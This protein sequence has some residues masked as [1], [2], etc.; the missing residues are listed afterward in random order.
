MKFR[1]WRFPISMLILVVF[2]SVFLLRDGEW[3]PL[4]KVVLAT[5]FTTAVT[6][7]GV[8]LI[9]AAVILALTVALGR[10]YCALL[11]P[12]GMVQDLFSR[13]G[14]RLG[15]SRLHYVRF[16]F[17]VNAAFMVAAIVFAGILLLDPIAMFGSLALPAG[18]LV[19]DGLW[20]ARRFY[21]GEISAFAAVL[22]VFGVLVVVPLFFGRVFCDAACPVGTLFRLLGRLPGRR[23]VI[24]PDKCVSCGKCS[25]VCAARCAD[26]MGKRIDAERCLLC[27]DCA[28]ACRFDAVAYGKE[29]VSGRRGFL[30]TAG[31]V[32]L[33]GTFVFSREMRQRLGIGYADGTRVTPPGTGGQVGHAGRCVGCQ[34]CVLSCPV[35]II[36]ADGLDARPV[37]DFRQGYCQYNC[38]DCLSSCPAGVFR[39]MELGEKQ[40]TRLARIGFERERCVVVI[41]N[42]ACGACAEVCPTHALVM[43]E[44]GEGKPT[45]P[46]FAPDH[47][48]GCGAC[49]HVCPSVPRAFTVEGLARHE[50]SA[51]VRLVEHESAPDE[52]WDAGGAEDM[53][54]FPF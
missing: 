7:V 42:D 14:R 9:F 26:P 53:T 17:A 6:H 1:K 43:V 15:L 11:C 35:G 20:G 21:A 29:H 28:E 48:I 16:P 37:L 5:Q 10:F 39:R 51:G 31:A 34:A 32:A 52:P 50:R 25:T 49:F 19:D 22:T 4:R 23:L 36:R 2:I 33:G 45:V 13:I 27:F 47:C 24:A 3:L 12:A 18:A 41:K 54:D 44:Q 46:D 38:R 30:G 8:R 40:T